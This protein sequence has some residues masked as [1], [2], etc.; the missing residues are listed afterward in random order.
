MLQALCRADRLEQTQDAQGRMKRQINSACAASRAG[1]A[2]RRRGGVFYS[3]GWLF[4]LS[5]SA[6]QS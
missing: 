3:F 2:G 4:Q 5:S 6:S 1:R